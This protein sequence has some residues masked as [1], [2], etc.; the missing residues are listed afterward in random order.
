MN[1]PLHREESDDTVH[2]ISLRLCAATLD[3]KTDFAK[4]NIRDTRL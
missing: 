4:L 2:R 1:T 3:G